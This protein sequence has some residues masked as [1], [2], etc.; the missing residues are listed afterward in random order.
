MRW[1]DLRARRKASRE[2]SSKGGTGLAGGKKTEVGPVVAWLSE[3]CESGT[4][5]LADT[6]PLKATML[7]VPA[8]AQARNVMRLFLPLTTGNKL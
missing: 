4:C 2:R 5:A 8:S 1:S 7:A 3:A 6:M